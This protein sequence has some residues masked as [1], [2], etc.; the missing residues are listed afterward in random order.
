LPQIDIEQVLAERLG[1]RYADYRKAWYGAKPGS[2]PDFPIHLDLELIDYCNQNCFFCARNRETHPNLPFKLNTGKKIGKQVLSKLVQEAGREKLMSINIA[3]GE[4]LLHPGV[5]EVVRAFHDAGVV[6]SRMVT[7]GT[8]LH[9]FMNDVFESGL[10]NL[11]ISIDAFTENTYK[12]VR[13]A[14]FQTVVDNVL[15]LLE[16]RKRR[17]SVLPVVRVSFVQMELNQHELE[18]FKRFWKDKVDLID[19]NFRTQYNKTGP[20]GKTQKWK[21]IDPFRRLAVTALGEIL[22]CCAFYGKSMVIGDIREMTLREAWESERM[23]QMRENLLNDQE[24][25]CLA[26]QEC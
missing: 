14:G 24:P 20:V 9:R 15:H 8:L 4:P 26:C 5:F 22:P 21:C 6:D 13:G 17:G 7:N 3:F 23:K 25:L 2:V 1:P 11:Y 19:I 18:D 16:E 10:V 12:Q